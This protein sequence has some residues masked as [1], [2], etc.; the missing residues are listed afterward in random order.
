MALTG[1]IGSIDTTAAPSFFSQGS[2]RTASAGS[3]AI[4]RS[5]FPSPIRGVGA[6]S[7]SLRFVNTLPPRCAMPIVSADRTWIPFLIAASAMSL[8]ARMVPCP[9][10][11]HRMILTCLLFVSVCIFMHPF[12]SSNSK[13][14]TRC[15]FLLPFNSSI[16]SVAPERAA[17]TAALRT[18]RP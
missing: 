13:I 7:P 9:P 15:S 5:A 3:K 2:M 6:S 12:P 8:E 16:G 14:P 11:P 17:A 1:M 10:T 4:I 18:R